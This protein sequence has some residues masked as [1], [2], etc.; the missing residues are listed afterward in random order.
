M[1]ATAI[2]EL[3][4]REWQKQVVQLATTLGW[5]AYHVMDSRRSS[6]GWPDLA[7]VRDRVIYAELKTAKGKLSVHQTRWLALLTQAGAECYL[8]RPSDLEEVGAVLSRRGV[9]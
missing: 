8:W 7:L 1:T 6:H 5:A 4:E 9:A 2:A 3:S